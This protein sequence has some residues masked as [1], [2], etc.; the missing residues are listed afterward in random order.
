VHYNTPAEIRRF[1]E[2]LARMK[3]CGEGS[4]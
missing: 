4:S 1:G 2:L 3:T